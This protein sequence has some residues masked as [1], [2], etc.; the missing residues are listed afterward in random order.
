MVHIIRYDSP[1]ANDVLWNTGSEG[2]TCLHS[3]IYC[4]LDP[5]FAEIDTS[6]LVACWKPSYRNFASALNAAFIPEFKSLFPRGMF[7]ASMQKESNA[8]YGHPFLDRRTTCILDHL[9]LG[10]LPYRQRRL[11]SLYDELSTHYF[12]E[13][14]KRYNRLSPLHRIEIRDKANVLLLCRRM[15]YPGTTLSTLSIYLERITS[16]H[17]NYSL[18]L[19]NCNLFCDSICR[20]GLWKGYTLTE[21]NC[22]ASS[23]RFN[24]F[25]FQII[26]IIILAIVSALIG[27]FCAVRKL[28]EYGFSPQWLA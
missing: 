11:N 23:S 24:L 25:I 5:I 4:S 10:K 13:L 22:M 8:F 27:A 17:P 6:L 14:S 20:L 12:T 18:S 7:P 2:T 16:R 1:E 15:L 21:L 26:L 28:G 3:S 9:A 19:M